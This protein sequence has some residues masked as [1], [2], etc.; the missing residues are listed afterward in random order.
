MAPPA[1]TPEE[2]HHKLLRMKKM[3]EKMNGG[4]GGGGKRSRCDSTKMV[5]AHRLG[6]SMRG[7]SLRD[8][9]VIDCLIFFF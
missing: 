2:Q 3:Q 4:G 9:M 7:L 1:M 5:Q 6:Q 8:F